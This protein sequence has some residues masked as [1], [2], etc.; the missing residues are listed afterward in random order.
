MACRI[1]H[2]LCFC[3]PAGSAS[4]GRRAAH[5]AT[6]WCSRSR[7]IRAIC[8]AVADVRHRK[9]RFRDLRVPAQ[10]GKC[11]CAGVAFAVVP[12]RSAERR[13]AGSSSWWRRCLARLRL[14]SRGP[15]LRTV[16]ACG[17]G[18]CGHC[19]VR[20]HVSVDPRNVLAWRA[21][22]CDIRALPQSACL[23]RAV[24]HA[25]TSWFDCARHVLRV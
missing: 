11:I 3:V 10:S 20:A 5:A 14:I 4:G 19:G 13:H 22:S 21:L 8:E 1:R 9:C 15:S 16:L 23:G 24:C 17:N 12:W 18:G 25:F 2:H 6:R 7:H